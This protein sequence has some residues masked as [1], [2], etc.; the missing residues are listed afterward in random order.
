MTPS[1]YLNNPENQKNGNLFLETFRSAS[2]Q[3]KTVSEKETKEEIYINSLKKGK[4][5]LSQN[6]FKS[7]KKAFLSAFSIKKT[8]EIAHLLSTCFSNLKE[9]EYACRFFEKNLPHYLENGPYWGI[10][11]FIIILLKTMKELLERH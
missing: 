8:I 10:L 11:C 6:D 1:N 9:F 3:T 5:S 2:T 7:A 4:I